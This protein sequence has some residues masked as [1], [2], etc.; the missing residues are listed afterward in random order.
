MKSGYGFQKFS[1]GKIAFAGFWQ[2]DQR[3]G[4]GTEFYPNGFVKVRIIKIFF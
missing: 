2:K 3:N 1:D 4:E